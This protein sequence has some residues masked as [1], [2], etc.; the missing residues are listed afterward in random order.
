[1]GIDGFE[2][3]V[4]LT[5]G[6]TH[7]AVISKRRILSGRRKRIKSN[8][9]RLVSGGDD[10]GTGSDAASVV[11]RE[12]SE[13]RSGLYDVPAT[14]SLSTGH[15]DRRQFR[16]MRRSGMDSERVIV[17]ESDDDTEYVDGADHILIESSD[18]DNMAQDDKKPLSITTYEGFQIYQRVLCLVVKKRDPGQTVVVGRARKGGFNSSLE[19]SLPDAS[20]S[21]IQQGAVEGTSFSAMPE[22]ASTERGG[23][24][25][26]WITMTQIARQEVDIDDM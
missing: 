9:S 6:G 23:M 7:H 19:S 20:G 4:F 8:S 2:V 15:G 5:E 3:S 17:P 14:G 21:A 11:I 10:D 16:R 24:M 22:R 25:E 1:M 13:E 12:E 26:E 18:E